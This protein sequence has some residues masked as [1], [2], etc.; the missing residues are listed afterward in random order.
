MVTKWNANITYYVNI[1]IIVQ[2]TQSG[3]GKGEMLSSYVS[4]PVSST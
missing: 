1:E 3:K 2:F 4:M